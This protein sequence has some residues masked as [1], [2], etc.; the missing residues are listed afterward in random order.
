LRDVIETE[1][2]EEV[3]MKL[4][5]K[6]MPKLIIPITVVV[7]LAIAIPMMSGCLPGR[8]AAEAPVEPIK[9]GIGTA[10]TGLL[11][12]DGRHHIRAL[13]IARNE[14]N[15]AGGLLGRPVE[16][17]TV[18]VGDCTT[19][20]LV[21]ARDLLKEADVDVVNTNWFKLPAAMTYLV[22]VGVLV[23]HHGWVSSDWDQWWAIRDEYPYYMVLNQGEQG[24]G[25]PYFQGLMNPE[26]I[27]WEYPN[28]TAAVLTSDTIYNQRKGAWWKEEA[29]R[30][31]W[32]IVF[33]QTHPAGHTEFGPQFAKIRAL[34]PA[35]AIVYMNSVI[36]EE[37]IPAF[38]EF[39]EAPTQSLYIMTWMIEKPEFLGAFG[40]L[41][42][43]C[44]G[45][46]PGFFFHDSVY[47]G[48]N[49]HYITHY[50]KGTA[51]AALYR[52]RYAEEPSV[53]VPIAYD[54][55]WVWAEAVER[56]GNVR[57]FDAIMEAMFDYSYVGATGT[58]GF[59]RETHAGSYGADKIPVNY[60]Q[61]Q[62]GKI[63]NLA[64]GVGDKV[65]LVDDFLMPYWIEE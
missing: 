10:I 56:V 32:E 53:Q 29:V 47:T 25:A 41:A 24:Y 33:D 19:P 38:A 2:L 57:D 8:P 1:T 62:D 43:G 20:E 35:P 28:K 16:L 51:L 42:D 60:F 64:I 37:A 36:S 12:D 14:I 55:F 31:G 21:A 7:V 44:I 23:I 30:Q 61:L 65:S 50:E 46:L 40:E 17:V 34:D 52:Q 45:T 27:T 54:S 9:V 18:D 6:G 15:S 11:A 48:D 49:P 59:D 22:E 13:E 5:R 58:Y 39:L 26:M 4:K 63:L 3:V